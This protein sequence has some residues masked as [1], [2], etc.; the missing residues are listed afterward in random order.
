M[1]ILKLENFGREPKILYSFTRFPPLKKHGEAHIVSITIW[2]F[3]I[4]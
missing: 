1:Q 3:P 4:E 2:R